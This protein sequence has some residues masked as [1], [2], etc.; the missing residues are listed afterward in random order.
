MTILVAI[1]NDSVSGAVID[2][3]VALADAM[4]E[5]LYVVHLVD[6]DTADG[7]AKQLRD[8]MRERFRDAT[9]VATVAI[10]HVGR[11]AMRSGTRVGNELLELAADVDVHHIV[12]GHEPKGLTGR[13]REGDAAVAVIDAADVPVTIVPDGKSDA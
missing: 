10:E 5:E 11:S 3:A 7:T 6:A 13:I 4:D 12:M 1:A 9:V 2:T 8:E